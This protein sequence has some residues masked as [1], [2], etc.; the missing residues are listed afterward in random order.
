M[1]L[2][3]SAALYAGLVACYPLAT[4]AAPALHDGQSHEAHDHAE[5]GPHGGAIF[6]MGDE[7]YHIEL[8]LDEKRGQVTIV[9]LDSAAKQLVAIEE[10]HML[11]NVRSAG[12]P[13]Q[14]KLV[15]LY[16]EGQSGGPAAMYAIVSPELMQAIHSHNAVV[17]VV[18]KIA[19]KA[20]SASLH[21]DHGG[22]SH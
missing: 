13:Q 9:L 6:A 16:P 2:M 7:D 4:S 21:H 14:F 8:V 17:R 12:Q 3:I 22:H 5:K 1:R 18:V 19:G 20:Y 10:P 15:P 11:V